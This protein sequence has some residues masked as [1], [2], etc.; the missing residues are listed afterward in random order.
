MFR[1]RTNTKKPAGLEEFKASFPHLGQRSHSVAGPP[2]HSLAD[3]L[4]VAHP[5]RN[6]NDHEDIKD[7]DPTPRGSNEPWRFTP[8]LLD[9]NSFAFTSFANQPP[10]YY[11]P[12]PG[13]TNTL[14]HSQA[15]DLHT[16]GFSFGLGTPLS[17]PTSE[18]A[19]H[20]GQTVPSQ[21][22]HGFT[23]HALGAH[24]FQNVNPFA[25]QSQHSQS[26]APHQFTHQ[27]SAFDHGVMAQS[28]DEPSMDNNMV[29][30]MEMQEQS[31]LIGYAPQAYGSNMA[32][33]T[34]THL[35]SAPTQNFRY[36]VTLNA[37]TAMIKQSDEVPVTYLNKGQAYSISLVD[38]AP[39]QAPS[40]SLRYRT[41]IRISF[42][43]EQQRQRPAGCWQLWKEGRGTNEAHQRG[44]RLQAVEFVDPSQVGG[45][46]AQQ[47]RPRVELESSSFDGFV[48][49]WTPAHATAP[50]CSLAVR[51]N[52]LSTDFS[53]SKGVKGIPVR[54]CAKTE[55][56]TEAAA[57]PQDTSGP[58][59]CYCKVKLF[60]DHG[61]ERK[62]S[63]DVAHVK[64]TIDKMKQQ[65]AQAESGMKDFGKR[66]RSGSISKSSANGRPG[67][68][69]KHKRTWSLSSASS[70]TGAR[71][72]AEE[73]LHIKLAALQDMFSSTRPVSVLY[74]KGDE[75]DD[76]DLHPVQLSSAPSD[77]SKMETTVDAQMWEAT[78]SQTA[79]S[80]AVS[81]TP[82]SQSITSEKRRTSFQRPQPFQPPSRMPSNEWRNVP[83]TATG[84]LKAMTAIQGG[85]DVPTKVQRPYADDHA[86]SGW[87][88]ALGVDQTYQPPPEPMLKPVACFFVQPRIA[89][90]QSDDNYYRAIYLME[91]TVK[92]LV[93]SIAVK[94]KVEPTKVTRTIRI[95]QKG[96]Q[97]L[98]DDEAINR[99][100]EQQDM[101]AE[102]HEIGTPPT[103]SMK[104]EWDAGPTDVQVDGEIN[105]IE[106]IHSS[107]YELR[108]L[109]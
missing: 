26:F 40:L 12:T 104:R 83:Q 90:R 70:N 46:E 36:H 52:F 9:P 64:K 86:L 53:H 67:K 68:V 50:E 55:L 60:R 23:P 89:G 51:F 71:P 35:P 72:A 77:L 102:F 22:H 54:L 88:E 98:M 24:H 6:L 87:I 30:E 61:A 101:T 33:P 93:S 25:M 96:L 109:F 76:P 41:F 8:S 58:E 106:N 79:A 56:M 4:D 14:Y 74:L 21:L 100:P 94:A 2:G 43:D 27:P 78:G 18:G 85:A 105:V 29:P 92:E 108:L 63:N 42:E 49:N 95:N 10:G 47:G 82:S 48:V 44:G 15:G 20:A 39:L 103:Q 1:N 99:I 80:S 19:L 59:L 37:P 32:A 91:R 3:A 69:A 97:I 17:L 38:T 7:Q 84:D 16:P 62:L 57:P 45:G 31:P 75:Q 65:I 81:P 11:T 66:K 5:S 107:G 13:G 34:A 73:D 28:H